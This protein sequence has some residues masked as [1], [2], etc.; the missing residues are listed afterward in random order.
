MK[1]RA[2]N[3]GR[4]WVAGPTTGAGGIT[5]AGEV[6]F[7]PEG[8]AG[9]V[10]GAAGRGAT[11]VVAAGVAGAVDGAVAGPGDGRTIGP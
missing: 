4:C 2:K 5:C 6:V 11:G 1:R 3:Y 8:A 10:A 9:I 7:A